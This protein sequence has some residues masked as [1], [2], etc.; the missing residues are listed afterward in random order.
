MH[1]R[2]PTQDRISKW[3]PNKNLK[4]SLCSEETDS[5]EHLFFKCKY[6]DQIWRVA[7]VKCQLKKCNNEW[8]IILD[9]LIQM[10]NK[11]NIWIIIKKITFAACVYHVWQERNTRIFQGVKKDWKEGLQRKES[12]EWLALTSQLPSYITEMNL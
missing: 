5:H 7:M 11:R 1:R 2:L 3:W 8:K 6:V 12:T 10:P 9:E 4:C